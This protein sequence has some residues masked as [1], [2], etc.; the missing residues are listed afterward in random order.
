[1]LIGLSTP[2]NV[3]VFRAEAYEDNYPNGGNGQTYAPSHAYN[4]KTINSNRRETNGSENCGRYYQG[5]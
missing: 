1:M 5:M 3:G 2:P 4:T